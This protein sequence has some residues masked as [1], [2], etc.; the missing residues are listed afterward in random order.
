MTATAHR[1]QYP[2][3][4]F[5]L[6]NR[7]STFNWAHDVIGPSPLAARSASWEAVANGMR[8]GAGSAF[9]RWPEANPVAAVGVSIW[10]RGVT[11][12]MKATH[13]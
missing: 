1:P 11:A 2:L 13:S 12:G 8:A 5:S 3:P 9:A 6:S 7:A 4:L 10:G